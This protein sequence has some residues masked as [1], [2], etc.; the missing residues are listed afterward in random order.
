MTHGG[1]SAEAV[2]HRRELHA[3]LQLLDDGCESAPLSLRQ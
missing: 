1:R 2:A 3:L